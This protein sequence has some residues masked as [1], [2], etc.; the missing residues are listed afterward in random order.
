MVLGS[1]A[2]QFG[3]YLRSGIICVLGIICGAVNSC[4]SAQSALSVGSWGES[5]NG[6]LM[7]T[8]TKSIPTLGT[9]HLLGNVRSIDGS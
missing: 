3:D 4:T 2:A 9:S 5:V 1:F 6:E 7:N 8:C